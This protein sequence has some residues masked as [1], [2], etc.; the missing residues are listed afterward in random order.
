ME[1]LSKDKKITISTRNLPLYLGKK[2]YLEPD[3]SDFLDAGVAHGLAWSELGGALL[4]IEIVL[5]PGKGDITLT[6]KLGEVMQE[7]VHTAFSY[8]KSRS[9]DFNIAYNNFSKDYNLHI[10][11]PEGATPKDGPSAGIAITTGIISA[12]TQIPIKSS[13]AMTGEV[14]LTGKILP[15]GGLRE[16]SLAALRHGK[17]TVIIPETNLKDIN[18]ISKQ[19]RNRIDFITVKRVDDL[20]KIVFEDNIYKKSTD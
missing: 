18:E 19:V 3:S 14:T 16:K 10:H 8:I 11:F 6:G 2:K 17:K 20:L 4:P 15:I 5:Y 12:L 13:I 1:E 9:N 7:S